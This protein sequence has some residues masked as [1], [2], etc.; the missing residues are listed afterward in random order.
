MNEIIFRASCVVTLEF[1]A[2][3]AFELRDGVL[4]PWAGRPQPKPY[5]FTLFTLFFRL[6]PRVGVATRCG[7]TVSRDSATDDEEVRKAMRAMRSETVLAVPANGTRSSASMLI[8]STMTRRGARPTLLV[9]GS[10]SLYDEFEAGF[11]GLDYSVVDSNPALGRSTKSGKEI[12]PLCSMTGDSR[13]FHVAIT[14]Q[15]SDE[16]L[17]LLHDSGLQFRYIDLFNLFNRVEFLSARRSRE[18]RAFGAGFCL[19]EARLRVWQAGVIGSRDLLTQAIESYREAVWLDP[20]LVA[21]WSEMGNLLQEMTRPGAEHCFERA[22]ELAPGR[23]D[24]QYALSE[25]H[26]RAGRADRARDHFERSIA[27]GFEPPGFKRTQAMQR[28]GSKKS[29]R[30]KQSSYPDAA[31]LMADTKTT[32][33]DSLL[34]DFRG[35]PPRM[36][37][38]TRF[39]TL[40]SC[41]ATNIQK[42][43]LRMGRQSSNICIGEDVNSTFAN[44]ALVSWLSEESGDSD[45]AMAGLLARHDRTREGMRAKIAEADLLIFTLGVSAAFYDAAAET[46]VLPA[47]SGYH[48]GLLARRYPFRMLSVQENV[49]N[50]RAVIDGLRLINPTL[51]VVLTVSPVPISTVVGSNSAVMSDC[52]SKSTVRISA[53]QVL[54]LGLPDVH[55][56]P[57]FEIFRWISP[58][59]ERVFGV[60]DEDSRHPAV[61]YVDMAISLFLEAEVPVA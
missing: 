47:M 5:N 28:Q 12:V 55:Y 13:E 9:F 36:T 15:Y 61:K 3:R 52:V 25:A 10:G 1:R 45:A 42:A 41:F 51:Q 2:D 58:H 48:A 54:K 17:T 44:R 38:A 14:S 31:S 23:G 30:I 43:L 53:E 34:A 32:I 50:I 20:A 6:C 8:D 7:G 26:A 27:L 60:D 59:V 11:Q 21:A 46:Y 37:A 16:I 49:E 22:I 39:F 40:G 18:G 57:S 24:L 19:I 4:A 29:T 35:S 56:Y 33:R